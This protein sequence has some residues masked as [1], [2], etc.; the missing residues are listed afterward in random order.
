MHF[1]ARTFIILK[2]E[3]ESTLIEK[4]HLGDW[5]REDYCL[6]L[7]FWQPVQKP[8]SESSDSLSWKFKIA[9]QGFWIFNWLRL[10]LYSEDGFCTG[11]REICRKQQSFSGLQ[12][13]RWSLSIKVC[14]SWV[15]TIF[16]SIESVAHSFESIVFQ[17]ILRAFI[18]ARWRSSFSC[19]YASSC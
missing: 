9:C 8:C 19:K 14:Y 12:S 18:N 11:C 4:D 6:Q 1:W 7:T 13:P 2:G 5:S 16:S 15:P 10:S 17:G 3:V